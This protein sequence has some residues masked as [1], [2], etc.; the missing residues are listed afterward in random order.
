[1]RYN[2]IAIDC[3]TQAGARL[4]NCIVLCIHTEILQGVDHITTFSGRRLKVH[5]NR[6]AEDRASLMDS[7]TKALVAC[8]VTMTLWKTTSPTTSTS[9]TLRDLPPS[10]YFTTPSLSLGRELCHSEL[11][12]VL[13]TLKAPITMTI[14][15]DLSPVR[16]QAYR[17][18]SP[19]GC[20]HF[21]QF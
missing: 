14:L 1:M 21:D 12:V 11:Q 13:S 4:S 5:S 15:Q 7:E 19:R 18:S 9:K 17:Y 8:L 2:Q 10:E 3:H 6:K 16:H 20:A